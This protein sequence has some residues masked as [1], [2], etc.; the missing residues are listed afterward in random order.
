MGSN[1]AVNVGHSPLAGVPS[2]NKM[3]NSIKRFLLI[4]ILLSHFWGHRFLKSHILI[5]VYIQI[6]FSFWS[7]NKK[8]Q[9]TQI[10]IL[11]QIPMM[12]PGSKRLC[13]KKMVWTED[14]SWVKNFH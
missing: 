14:D 6:N 8:T 4:Y 13:F 7:I 2:V 10:F 9:K 3:Y 12:H 5:H 11:F 1:C